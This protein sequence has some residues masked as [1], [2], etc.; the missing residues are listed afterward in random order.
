MDVK[1]AKQQISNLRKGA[2]SLYGALYP[3]RGGGNEL[4]DY[5]RQLLEFE[6]AFYQLEPAMPRDLKEEI[7]TYIRSSELLW[8]DYVGTYGYGKEV[9]EVISGIEGIKKY[10][11]SV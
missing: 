9:S 6:K 8:K 2:K 4:V 11:P 5:Y 3:F 10:L 1:Q 7:F